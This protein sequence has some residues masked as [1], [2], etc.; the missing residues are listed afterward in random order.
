M[1][2]F[3]VRQL[4]EDLRLAVQVD[5]RGRKRPDGTQWFRQAPRSRGYHTFVWPG[6]SALLKVGKDDVN[7]EDWAK[8]IEEVGEIHIWVKRDGP[9]IFWGRLNDGRLQR[10]N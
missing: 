5:I 9:S 2:L 7:Q 4:N 10:T 1:T 6:T 3:E 8:P